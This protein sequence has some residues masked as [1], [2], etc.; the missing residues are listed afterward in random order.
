MGPGSAVGEKG[1][2]RGQIGSNRKNIGER[3]LFQPQTTPLGSLRSSIFSLQCG[4]WSQAITQG[5]KKRSLKT[6]ASLI[7]NNVY[8]FFITKFRVAI[9]AFFRFTSVTVLLLFLFR[10]TNVTQGIKLSIVNVRKSALKSIKL[11]SLKIVHFKQ[12]RRVAK[13]YR[14]LYLVGKLA[15]LYTTSKT[16]FSPHC[17][18]FQSRGFPLLGGYNIQPSSSSTNQNVALTIDQKLDLLNRFS[19][20]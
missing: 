16:Q 12:L 15:R 18:S 19:Q 4:A 6:T 8:C 10:F 2:K 5:L 7:Q 20:G 13:F 17:F 1:K 9:P 3:T 14:G 11:P